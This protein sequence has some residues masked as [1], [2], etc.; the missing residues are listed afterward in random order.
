MAIL[1]KTLRNKYKEICN[2]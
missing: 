2:Y 1:K